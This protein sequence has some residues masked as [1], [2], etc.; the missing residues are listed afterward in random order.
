MPRRGIALV[1]L[2]FLN[3]AAGCAVNPV[4]GQE[5]LMF[6]SPEQ[7]VKLGRKYAPAI[8]K[9]LQGR[10]PDETLQSYVHRIGQRIARVCHRP[11]L[12]YHFTAVDEPSENAIAVPGG[13]VYI[14]RGLLERLESEAQLAAVLAHEVGHVV[15][16][17]TMAAMSRQYGMAAL[18][19]AAQVGGAPSDV[20][21]GASFITAVLSLQYSR[22]DERDADL[23]GL[24]YMVQAGYDPEGMVETMRILQDLQTVRPVEFFSTHPNPESRLAYL[25]ERIA[26]RY[27]TLGTLKEGRGEYEAAV[28]SR[29]EEYKRPGR[30]HVSDRATGK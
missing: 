25:Q 30:A 14:T 20:T 29:L 2:A 22:E 4:T 12:S 7:D 28:L 16:R 11:D 3:F 5:E 18:V 19:A 6:F 10:I 15:A 17:D 27:A 9:A 24:S 1:C 23:T 13:Y 8:E 26:R 21:R